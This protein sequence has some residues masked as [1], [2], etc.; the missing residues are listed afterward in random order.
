M[1]APT[2]RPTPIPGD[3]VSQI[4]LQ[5]GEF[6]CNMGALWPRTRHLKVVGVE[7]DGYRALSPLVMHRPVALDGYNQQINLS[8]HGFH[9][10]DVT[11]VG[12]F[13]CGFTNAGVEEGTY[14]NLVF[15]AACELAKAIWTSVPIPG[16]DLPVPY[17]PTLSGG[18]IVSM[19]LYGS[20][21]DGFWAVGEVTD[22]LIN[23]ISI[24]GTGENRYR[25]HSV[26]SYRW[27]QW[28]SAGF[29]PKPLATS[30]GRPKRIH[31]VDHR[32]ADGEGAYTNGMV[33][34]RE[35]SRIAEPKEITVGLGTK[36]VPVRRI[37]SLSS[38]G[39]AH[40]L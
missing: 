39:P 37:Q 30:E 9:A 22:L 26:T 6:L 38:A 5:P 33:Y 3:D 40:G 25:F 24:A 19:R 34:T 12:S 36:F 21:G 11:A 35:H 4:V 20:G 29:P 15:D 7:K 14:T 16:L 32:M 27:P 17:G 8:L 2:P 18:S 31:I 1:P 10:H 23:Q 13:K 28:S